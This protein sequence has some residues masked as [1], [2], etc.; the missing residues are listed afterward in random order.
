VKGR[1]VA[2]SISLERGGP[3]YNVAEAEFVAGW[4]IR[5]D[6]HAD[7]GVRQVSLLAVESIHRLD[8]E[9]RLEPGNFA[10]NVTTCG[11]ELWALPLKARLRLG[12]A[13]VLE[14]TQ[15]GK[16]CHSRCGIYYRFGD[17]IMPRE[18]VFA[19]VV[20]GGVVRPGDEIVLLGRE[21]R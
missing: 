16:V 4:G 21:Q 6:A 20:Q 2:V 18:G 12:K 15:Q 1:V 10:E 5:G 14:I 8:P 9:G 13:V 11:V 7:G 19:A 17:C 3:K